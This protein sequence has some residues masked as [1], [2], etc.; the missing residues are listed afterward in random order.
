MNKDQFIDIVKQLPIGKST[1]NAKYIHISALSEY[2]VFPFL[3]KIQSALKQEKFSWTVAKLWKKE[4]KFSLLNYPNFDSNAYP[5]LNK[6]LFVDLEK[7]SHKLN[8]YA[9]S[10]NPPILHRKEDMVA[11]D[12]VS[13]DEFILITQEGEMAGLYENTNSIGFKLSWLSLIE[14]NGYELVDG[15][16]FRRSSVIN[17]NRTIDRHKTAI[18]RYSLSAPMKLLQKKGYL[19]GTYNIFDYGCGLGDDLAELHANGITANGWDPNFRPEQD[20][21]SA[22]IVNLGFVLNVIE[23]V[24]E[25]IEALHKAFSLA[26][27]MLI[28]SCMLGS[29]S[30]ISSFKQY[31]DGVITSRNTFQKYYTQQE[32][33]LF[34]QDTLEV[35]PISFGPGIFILFKDEIEEQTFLTNRY[36]RKF[37]W[38]SNARK[39]NSASKL[40]LLIE[41]N[42]PLVD[43]FLLVLLALGR[44]PIQ[45]EFKKLT[46][47]SEVFGSP[48]RLLKAALNDENLELLSYAEETR[49]QD[50]LVYFALEKFS[51]RK[52]YNSM[53]IE[54]RQDIKVF[55]GKYSDAQKQGENL[56]FAI[57]DVEQMIAAAQEA[58][59]ALPASLLCEG[60]SLFILPR[61]V[62]LLPALLRV[63]VGAASIL[64]G[65]WEEADVIKIHLTSGKVTFMVYDDFDAPVPFLK[66]RVKVKLAQQDIDYF[67]Y[68]NPNRRPPLIGKSLLMEPD[69][70]NYK[71]QFGLDKKLLEYGILKKNTENII[72]RG[73]WHNFLNRNSL[74]LKGFRFFSMSK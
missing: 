47:I 42:R 23:D 22:D 15:R 19:D 74:E 26:D 21:V 63:Y 58:H 11:S 41:Q 4:F 3:S 34:L 10:D 69:D 33:K 55:F 50:Y 49:R 9:D 5:E 2:P 1:P 59:S 28:V 38:R 43:E 73:E 66:E 14:R 45:G 37:E 12:Y 68:V 56:L 7:M 25:R 6:S 16:L 24:A 46:E 60:E 39:P 29:E 40:N 62:E 71:K 64:Y 53:P 27:S 8:D 54:K 57:A 31:K 65:D 18:T 13:R 32:L 70:T 51:Q 36:K 44:Q 17:D 61:Y 72:S 48:K 67:D 35:E 52:A 30:L 20:L